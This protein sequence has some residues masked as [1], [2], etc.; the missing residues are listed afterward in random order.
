MTNCLRQ[1][2]DKFSNERILVPS[3]LKFTFSFDKSIGKFFSQTFNK[4][5]TL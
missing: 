3:S 2:R 4:S 5:L 1:L